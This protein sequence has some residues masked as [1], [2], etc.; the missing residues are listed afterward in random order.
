MTRTRTIAVVTGSRA[1]Y[2]LLKP[3]LAAI[4]L[5]EALT[6]KLL[7][8]GVHL[9]EGVE[10]AEEIR[11]EWTIAAE[12]P[13]QERGDSGQLADARSLGRGII[14]IATEFERIRPDVVVVLGDRIEA[15]AAASA[16]SV[17]GIPLA[18][19]HGGDRAEGIADEAIRHAVTKL[20][21]VHFPATAKSAER[22]ERMGEDPTTINCVGSPAVDGIE[23]V[24]PLDDAT[25]EALGAPRTIFLMHGV[26]EHATVEQERATEVLEACSQHGA[27][28]ALAPNAD[29]GSDGVRAAIEAS[30]PSVRAM[31][32]LPRRQ[33]I[34]ALKRID[35]LVG[36]SS[37]GLIEAAVIGCNAINIGSRQRG[38]ERAHN[39]VDLGE[40]KALRASLSELATR[41][42]PC[43]HPY[44]DGASG[45]R[46]AEVLARL[47]L[48]TLP[49]KC[50]IY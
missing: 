22:I 41:S 26:G 4:D 20:A 16:A 47:D 38:R 11:R 21:N 32:H 45:E 40:P 37:A 3:V 12:V 24:P 19:L 44:G 39:V 7:V 33:F 34:G 18:H 23:H 2:G 36:N 48:A 27:V 6:L 15:F 14:G 31:P 49:R 35:V 10:T 13:M 5:H 29:A 1:E 30:P 50:S 43:D 28:L 42:V 9:L 46:V 25:F 8:T 17:G